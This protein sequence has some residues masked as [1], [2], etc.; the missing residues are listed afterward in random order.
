MPNC[1]RVSA[2]NRWVAAAAGC[3]WASGG[4]PLRLSDSM[5]ACTSSSRRASSSA[6]VTSSAR[7]STSVVP[8]ARATAPRARNRDSAAS[9]NGRPCTR[10]SAS[11]NSPWA[12]CASRPDCSAASWGRRT[13]PSATAGRGAP[14]WPASTSSAR[15]RSFCGSQSGHRPGPLPAW[16]AA[17]SRCASSTADWRIAA[18]APPSPC[19]PASA[20]ACRSAAWP[21]TACA[22]SRSPS[23]CTPWLAR[24]MRSICSSCCRTASASSSSSGRA[25]SRL[26]SQAM[27]R[28]ERLPSSRR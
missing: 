26:T 27:P 7:S 5:V 17:V 2:T 10:T 25:A 3:H 21:S 15:R 23:T 11:A 8:L 12:R 24:S 1:S 6:R 22:C 20:R 18:C 4:S 28:I 14:P 16:R 19:S 9:Q 13:R